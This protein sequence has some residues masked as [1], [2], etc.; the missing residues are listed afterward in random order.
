M[1]EQRPDSWT[2]QEVTVYYGPGPSLHT[3]TLEAV[4]KDGFIVSSRQDGAEETA[5][6][7]FN[8]VARLLHG[9][10]AGRQAEVN[11]F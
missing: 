6:Y 4:T 11:S 10:P 5:F 8:S 7:P 2:G 1:D 9:P 3:G